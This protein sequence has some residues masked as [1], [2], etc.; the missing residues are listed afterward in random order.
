MD[1]SKII[2]VVL[3]GVVAW[4]VFS[5]MTQPVPTIAGKDPVHYDPVAFHWKWKGAQDGDQTLSLDSRSTGDRLGTYVGG[6][7]VWHE[8]PE[9]ASG[10]ALKAS[11]RDDLYLGRWGFDAG[12]VLAIADFGEARD[13]A[14]IDNVQLG[15]RI[16]PARIL[17]DTVALDAVATND[18][19]GAGISVYAPERAVG[20]F[21]SSIGVGAW[22]VVPWDSRRGDPS[23]ALG[24]T[25][26]FNH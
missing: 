5:S 1:F 23:P 8:E 11:I 18:A 26:S 7:G 10:G 12:P 2:G 25:A 21:W 20:P 14:N 22:Y 16:S 13:G 3:L 4:T 24:L 15:V 17:F 6:G 9:Q 19:V